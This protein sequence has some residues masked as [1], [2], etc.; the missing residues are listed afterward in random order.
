MSEFPQKHSMD[1][2]KIGAELALGHIGGI[3]SM[4]S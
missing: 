4:P 1:G 3:G 2:E